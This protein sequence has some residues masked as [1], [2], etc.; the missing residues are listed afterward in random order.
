MTHNTN[1]AYSVVMQGVNAAFSPT[2]WSGYSERYNQFC[3]NKLPEGDVVYGAEQAALH[4][5]ELKN[6]KENDQY[7]EYYNSGVYEI[8]RTITTTIIETVNIISL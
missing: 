5:I 6:R 7:D 2:G 4:A 3:K 8:V 1:V